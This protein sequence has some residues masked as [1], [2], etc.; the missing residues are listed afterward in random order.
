MTYSNK[1][2]N[3]L[4]CLQAFKVIHPANTETPDDYTSLIKA[5]IDK[6]GYEEVEILV[7][8]SSSGALEQDDSQKLDQLQTTFKDRCR[9]REKKNTWVCS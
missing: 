4:A 1:K 6:E 7:K 8:M 5:I 9:H 3:F 2:Q